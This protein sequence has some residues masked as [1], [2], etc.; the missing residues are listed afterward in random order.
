MDKKG[1]NSHL[2]LPSLLSRLKDSKNDDFLS[3]FE[4]LKQE[5]L[6]NI[7]MILNSRV[8]PERHDLDNDPFIYRSVLGF[9]LSDCCGVSHSKYT[10]DFILNEIREL[11]VFFEPR[12]DGSSVVVQRIRAL[13]S[14]SNIEIQIS[15]RLSVAP[16]NDDV[17]FFF[18]LDLESGEQKVKK[19]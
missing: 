4:T 14:T 16:Y 1:K 17:D 6:D 9:G 5:I 15:G 13:D 3:D 2:Y 18:T 19:E 11:V 7:S 8:R 10:V 12:L